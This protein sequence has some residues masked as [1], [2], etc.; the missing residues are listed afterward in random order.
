MFFSKAL[1]AGAFAA[2]AYAQSDI[3]TFTSAPDSVTAGEPQTLEYTTD[4]LDAPVTITLR[5]GEADNLQDVT[6]LTDSA[7]GGSFTWTPS[8]DLTDGS[9]Y[10]L[11]ITQGSEVNYFGPFSVSGG[12]E[13][14]TSIPAS[15]S[16]VTGS[17]SIMP[18]PYPIPTTDA[19]GS[20][21]LDVSTTAVAISSANSTTYVSPIG[22][23][24]VGT[25]SSYMPRN[26]TMSRA[27]LTPATTTQTTA[28]ATETDLQA[29]A[30]PTDEPEASE[31]G[32]AALS[33]K[34]A[35]AL[36]IGAAAFFL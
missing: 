35:L 8:N 33:A 18:V 11:Q 2:V 36:L 27:T 16:T 13:V 7:T 34:G 1:L 19:A 22:L 32:A 31:G 6:T 29:T 4:N 28:V 25:V 30:P 3:L 9:N 20:V 23:G 24:T 5:Q 12:S 17:M 21:S 15:L 26:T 14:V 10:A